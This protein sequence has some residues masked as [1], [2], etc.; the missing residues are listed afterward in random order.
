MPVYHLARVPSE[1]YLNYV[2]EWVEEKQEEEINL[3]YQNMVEE[4]FIQND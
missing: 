3:S 2:I 1:S 4:K